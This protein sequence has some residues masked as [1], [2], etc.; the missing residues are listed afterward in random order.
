MYTG[1]PANQSVTFG[2]EAIPNALD[3]WWCHGECAVVPVEGGLIVV[4]GGRNYWACT[5]VGVYTPT[6]K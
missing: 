1:S 5:I 6:Q 4:P 3:S 2:G